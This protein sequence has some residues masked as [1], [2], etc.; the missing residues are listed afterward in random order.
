MEATKALGVSNVS[1]VDEPIAAVL[2]YGIP[3]FAVPPH[4]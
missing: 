4:L 2:A 1:V 3:N